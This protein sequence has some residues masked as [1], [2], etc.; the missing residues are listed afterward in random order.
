[1]A[2]Y[3]KEFAKA[4]ANIEK[5]QKTL[6][7]TK[8]GDKPEKKTSTDDA[9]TKRPPQQI[10]TQSWEQVNRYSVQVVDNL[11][12]LSSGRDSELL[13]RPRE[14]TNPLQLTK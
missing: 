12:Y 9:Y 13:E 7:K 5:A 1:M 4:D 6:E 14:K 3:L 2:D 8:T 10:K 11:T